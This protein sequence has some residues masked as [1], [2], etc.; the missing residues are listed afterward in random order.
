MIIAA[1]EDAEYTSQDNHI[2][3][4]DF[5]NTFGT[6][7]HAR[8]LAIMSDLGCPLD[9]LEIVGDIYVDS[10]MAFREVYYKTITSIK[11]SMDII[12]YNTLKV[13]VLFHNIP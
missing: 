11:I 12:K 3:F 9:I 4:I 8:L 1:L 13:H 5:R 10:T 7:G 2:T 6:I